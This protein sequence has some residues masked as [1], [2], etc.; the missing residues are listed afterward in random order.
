M[1]ISN[2]S[3]SSEP[4]G[5]EP[6]GSNRATAASERLQALEAR[7]AEL[8]AE[9]QL[10]QHQVVM[11]DLTG[12]YN[13]RGFNLSLSQEWRRCTRRQ[14]PMSLIVVDID[15]FR[16]YNDHKGRA[17]GD[18]LLRHLAQVFI[19]IHK[20]AGDSIARYDGDGFA[21]VLPDTDGEGAAS[22]AETMRVRA[23]HAGVTLS[24][25]I[26]TTVPQPEQPPD[27]LLEVADSALHRAKQQGGNQVIAHRGQ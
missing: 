1:S 9:N 23:N 2:E 22:L 13:R 14:E 3:I 26:A 6:A 21:C 8:E 20:R 16:S 7:I 12:I 19:S 25:G 27:L 10:L 24:G 4:V 11:D 5:S 17:G 18:M 15:S